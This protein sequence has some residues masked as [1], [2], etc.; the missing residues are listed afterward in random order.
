MADERTPLMQARDIILE[1]LRVRLNCTLT[2]MVARERANNIATA[3][4]PLL[5][6]RGNVVRGEIVAASDEPP[7]V[8]SR[9]GFTNSA[10]G[11]GDGLVDA[12]DGE[13]MEEHAGRVI[14]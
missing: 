13:T 10:T 5:E 11:V 7:P 3:L 1:G 9:Y 8:R 2:E 6:P 14:K 4:I 12:Y